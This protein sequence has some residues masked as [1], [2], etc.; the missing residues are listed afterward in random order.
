MIDYWILKVE[1][2][3]I[4]GKNALVFNFSNHGLYPLPISCNFSGLG[5]LKQLLVEAIINIINERA[6]IH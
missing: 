4:K 3:E 1:N 2:I 6:D 5:H